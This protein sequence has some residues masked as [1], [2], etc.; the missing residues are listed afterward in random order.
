MWGIN[1]SDNIC[2]RRTN[3][4]QILLSFLQGGAYMG[5][6][7]LC[8]SSSKTFTKSNNSSLEYCFLAILQQVKPL[9]QQP[10]VKMTKCLKHLYHDPSSCVVKKPK[11]SWYVCVWY[12]GIHDQ[13]LVL[14]LRVLTLIY[15]NLIHRDLTVFRP[16][17][18]KYTRLNAS[19][20]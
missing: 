11:F 14:G 17:N 8:S 2:K 19:E 6:S 7:T 10:S 9:N 15:L 4:N 16:K 18:A 12:R 5:C 20:H 13:C 1:P 3:S